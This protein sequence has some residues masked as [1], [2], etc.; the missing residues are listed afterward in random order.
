M[1][2]N[3]PDLIQLPKERPCY[4]KH[5]TWHLKVAEEGTANSHHLERLQVCQIQHQEGTLWQSQ[6]CPH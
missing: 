3:S 2:L 1:Q 6:S 5:C 4:T